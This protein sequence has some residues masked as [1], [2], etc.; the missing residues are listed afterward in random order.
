MSPLATNVF[1]NLSMHFDY[2]AL[3]DEIRIGAI[4]R[5]DDIIIPRSNF[6]FQKDDKVV[7]LAKNDQIQVVENMFRI[8]SI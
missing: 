7:F 8:S 1:A 3:P 2:R 5:G 6:I 4:L